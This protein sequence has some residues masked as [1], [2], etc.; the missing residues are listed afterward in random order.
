MT[1]Q[2]L[3][4]AIDFANLTKQQ[5]LTALVSVAGQVETWPAV[6]SPAIP[7]ERMSKAE[8]VVIASLVTDKERLARINTSAL[9]NVGPIA[10]QETQTVFDAIKAGAKQMSDLLPLVG[11]DQKKLNQILKFLTETNRIAPSFSA[12]TN[13]APVGTLE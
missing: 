11:N 6:F 5:I 8:A 4:T 1:Q 3:L 10:S 13:A 2:Q 9:G 12:G 7:P